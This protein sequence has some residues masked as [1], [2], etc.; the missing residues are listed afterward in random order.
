MN[1]C[2]FCPHSRL[3]KGKLVCPWAYCILDSEDL[4][5]IYKIVKGK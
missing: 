1:K 2:D 3:K 4:E 5:K